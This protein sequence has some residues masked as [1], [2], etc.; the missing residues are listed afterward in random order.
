M[1]LYERIL[2]LLILLLTQPA[3]F[4]AQD[5]SAVQ[6]PNLGITGLLVY[7]KT[8]TE[9]HAVRVFNDP[10]LPLSVKSELII[11]Y[12]C[13]RVGSEQLIMQLISDMLRKKRLYYFK[14]LDAYFLEGKKGNNKHVKKFIENFEQVKILY[15]DVMSYPN[16]QL[17][18]SLIAEYRERNIEDISIDENEISTTQNAKLN[19]LDPLGSAGSLF[20]IYQNIKSN[21]LRKTNNIVEI[22]N[23]LRLRDVSELVADSRE[24]R[25]TK[26][27]R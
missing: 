21:N 6:L 13:L 25:E 19:P 8:T 16:Q 2:V 10:Q 3:I 14:D 23:T 17:A 5:D 4:Y 22:L 24:L 27:E 11:K 1:R 20:T 12:N 18:D 26:N 7:Y 9:N 15:N